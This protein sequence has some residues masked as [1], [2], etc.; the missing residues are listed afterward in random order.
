MTRIVIQTY[1]NGDISNNVRVIFRGFYM[2]W[3]LC[4]LA[5]THIEFIIVSKA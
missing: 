2:F 1:Q 3:T 5:V 4:S